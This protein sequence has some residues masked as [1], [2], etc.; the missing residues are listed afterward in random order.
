MVLFKRFEGNIYRNLT[1]LCTTPAWAVLSVQRWNSNTP[2]YKV[3][4]N[5]RKLEHCKLLL[6]LFRPITMN[7]G[8]KMYNPPSCAARLRKMTMACG[9]IT[10]YTSCVARQPL[11]RMIKVCDHY[12]TEAG[13]A[14]TRT[15]VVSLSSDEQN[16]ADEA[17]KFTRSIPYSSK[18]GSRSILLYY[19]TK[20]RAQCPVHISINGSRKYNYE[21]DIN[22][23]VAKIS[24]NSCS[25][26]NTFKNA[27]KTEPVKKTII[28]KKRDREPS[29]IP[30]HRV[31]KL[32]KRRKCRSSF[33][34]LVKHSFP[35]SSFI[36]DFCTNY[37]KWSILYNCER[38]YLK[39]IYF[40]NKHKGKRGSN[41]YSYQQ[42]GSSSKML[43]RSDFSH[44]SG[45]HISQSLKLTGG[46]FPTNDNCNLP[47][48]CLSERLSCI[49]FNALRC[50]WEW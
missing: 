12:T 34:C 24:N 28:R 2:S 16:G 32:L 47:W 41:L 1:E 49:S 46:M 38:F 4:R 7:C 11:W 27:E 35:S 45:Y 26:E 48:A 40:I 6:E 23:M 42:E 50:W 33:R 10:N 22:G 29:R 15:F 14:G 31:I 39:Y 17:S 9:R 21:T 37:K 44:H 5:Q 25:F 30:L 20:T 36:R 3:C 19:A 18:S 8:K 13:Y 43:Q